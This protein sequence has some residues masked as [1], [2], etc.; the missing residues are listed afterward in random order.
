MIGMEAGTQ[1]MLDWMQKDIKLEHIFETAEKCVRHKI[2]II[3]SVIVGFPNET[4]QSV[5]E[6]LSVVK[7]LRRMSDDFSVS[8][9]YYKPYPGNKIADELSAEGYRFPSG[10]E[11]WS[12]FDYVNSGKS[13]WLSDQQV[14]EI[15]LFKFYSEL[16][17]S[18][19]RISKSLFQK[20]AKWRCEKN[21]YRFPIEK[22]IIR[23]VKPAP[24]VS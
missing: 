7:K 15:E 8:I 13:D 2:A 6:T 14:K 21:I 3:F 17:W 20:I 10:L 18:K 22:N 23:F 24:K 1:F 12:N 9:Y 16:A 4:P 11:E 19:K 5:T